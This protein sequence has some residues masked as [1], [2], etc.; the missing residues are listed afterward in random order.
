MQH[1][2]FDIF[3]FV[4]PAVLHILPNRILLNDAHSLKTNVIGYFNPVDVYTTMKDVPLPTD[5][6]VVQHGLSHG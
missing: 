6:A 4:Q 1:H 3:L 5:A 2:S